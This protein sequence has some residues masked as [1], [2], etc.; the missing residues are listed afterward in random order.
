M[1]DN[2]FGRSYSGVTNKQR[3]EQFIIARVT[4]IVLGPKK[5]GTLI[6]DPDY[7]TNADIGKIRYQLLYHPLGSSNPDASYPPAWPINGFVKQY[8][9]ENEIVLIMRGPSPKLNDAYEN[10]QFFYF[11]PFG[12]WND[13]NHNGFPDLNEYENFLTKFKSQPGYQSEERPTPNIPLGYTFQEKEDIKNLKPFEGDVI[14]QARFGQSIRFGSTVSDLKSE[15]P[16]SNSGKNGDPITIISNEQGVRPGSKFDTF[17]EN[18]NKD[19]SAIYMTSTQEIFIEDL[20]SF[21]LRSFGK[22]ID[23][24]R[25]PVY[26]LNKPITFP[27]V[28]K[29]NADI[30]KQSLGNATK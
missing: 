8:P 27:S 18:I 6:P 26:T 30:D 28:L 13:S 15:N 10:Q 16:W 5:G 3:G 11:P 20:N 7:T 17:V 23:V 29:S 22:G 24:Q 21:P 19:G 12:L 14:L 9:V 25:Q 2:L 4:S 1:A